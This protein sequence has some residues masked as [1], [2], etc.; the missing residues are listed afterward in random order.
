MLAREGLVTPWEGR[1][2]L[3]G[4]RG[5]GFLPLEVARNTY[6]AQA[7]NPRLAGRVPGRSATLTRLSL[8]LDRAVTAMGKEA[9]AAPASDG[10]DFCGFVAGCT[11]GASPMYVGVPTNAAVCDGPAAT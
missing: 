2:G 5:G 4:S 3:L 11:P 7:S 9:D 8:A 1:F 10:G 6:A